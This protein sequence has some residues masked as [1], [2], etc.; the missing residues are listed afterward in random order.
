[1]SDLFTEL[2]KQRFGVRLMGAFDLLFPRSFVSF[3]KFLAWLPQW[4]TKASDAD[5]ALLATD[6]SNDEEWEGCHADRDGDCEW[7][8]CPQ[9]QDGEPERTGR[10]CPLDTIEE[11]W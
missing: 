8:H 9:I 4:L 3:T 11:E 7:A 6:L 10:H 1:M 2:R 5:R